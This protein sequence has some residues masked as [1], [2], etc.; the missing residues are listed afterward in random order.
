MCLS[1]LSISLS[2]YLA[3]YLFAYISVYIYIYLF[4]YLFTYIYMYIYIYFYLFIH[5]FIGDRIGYGWWNIGQ[6]PPASIMTT[7]F[8]H[9]HHWTSLRCDVQTLCGGSFAQLCTLCLFK[10]P[11]QHSHDMPWHAVRFRIA[12]ICS[13]SDCIGFLQLS[14]VL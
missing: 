11:F 6:Y 14:Q 7:F 12:T 10:P 2:I 13:W 1:I 5:I 8:R 3:I 9:S 4:I